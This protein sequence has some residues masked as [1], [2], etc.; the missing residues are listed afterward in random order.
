MAGETE[1]RRKAG[2]VADLLTKKY[3]KS[4]VH[5]YLLKYKDT[6]L[7]IL[8]EEEND[9]SLEDLFNFL[10]ITV[11]EPMESLDEAAH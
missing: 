3:Y 8:I 11:T 4:T 7:S 5:P 2:K 6:V 9:S 1:R 10:E